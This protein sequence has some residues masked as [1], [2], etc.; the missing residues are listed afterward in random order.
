MFCSLKQGINLSSNF[1][2]VHYEPVL[3]IATWIQFKLLIGNT[4]E[5]AKSLFLTPPS[6]VILLPAW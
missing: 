6:N 1:N 4:H 5:V 3:G 2:E